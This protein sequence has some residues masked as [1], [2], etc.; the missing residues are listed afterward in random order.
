M[1]FG[2]SARCADAMGTDSSF[3]LSHQHGPQ[4]ILEG[5]IKA[6][7]DKIS[8][9]WL[10]M[11]VPMDRQVL[12]K[13][14]KAGFSWR[15]MPGSPPRKE[16]LKAGSSH[17]RWRIGPWMDYSGFLAEHFA[18]TP[19]GQRMNKV[20][21][22]RYADDFLITRHIEG[23]S[24]W[25]SP[26]SRGSLLEGTRARIS[27]EKTQIT[28]V[29]EGFDFL[30]QNIRRYGCGKVLTKPSSQSVKT[31]L[32]KIRETIDNSGSLTAGVMIQRLNQ[33]IKGWTMYHR[34]AASKCTFTYVDH[35]IFQ[36]VWRW[37]RRRHRKKSRKWTE[38]NASSTTVTATGSSPV[39]CLTKK[40]RA[41]RSS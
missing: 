27:H 19:E 6:C 38:E 34:Y 1:A 33:Q 30:G 3:L 32:S 9:E 29:E 13:W 41:G 14:L 10:L 16:H 5:D 39:R 11:H 26:T 17:P 22:V 7:F 23:T 37:C 40:V 21:L 4:W 36:M 25:S 8:H 18:K 12:G 15:S 28:H 24:S 31:F 2:E 35:R 20:H